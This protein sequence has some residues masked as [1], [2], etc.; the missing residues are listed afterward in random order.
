MLAPN[1]FEHPPA[2][3]HEPAVQQDQEPRSPHRRR[4]AIDQRRRPAPPTRKQACLVP[5]ARA[6][7]ARDA[8][9]A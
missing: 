7:H 2:D 5:L 4:A 9:R 8:L 3:A 6:T 1:G